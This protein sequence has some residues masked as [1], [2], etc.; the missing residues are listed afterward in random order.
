MDGVYT[1]YEKL[2]PTHETTCPVNPVP[3]DSYRPA[4]LKLCFADISELNDIPTLLY[5]HM[6][7]IFTEIDIDCAFVY[8]NV[9]K[10][11]HFLSSNQILKYW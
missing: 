4:V 6:N 8:Y 9:F 5:N 3:R 1:R 10:W 7:Y 2:Y 11:T